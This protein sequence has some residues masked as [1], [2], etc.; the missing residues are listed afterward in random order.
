MSID[1]K[2]YR[3]STFPVK[4]VGWYNMTDGKT[5][6]AANYLTDDDENDYKYKRHSTLKLSETSKF[7]GLRHWAIKTIGGDDQEIETISVFKADTGELW[8]QFYSWDDDYDETGTNPDI[9]FWDDHKFTVFTFNPSETSLWFLIGIVDESDNWDMLGYLDLVSTGFDT[10]F[11]DPAN[12]E[13]FHDNYWPSIFFMNDDT[14]VFT[15]F[16]E[17]STYTSKQYSYVF[18]KDEFLQNMDYEQTG[19]SGGDDYER[20]VA[21]S[22]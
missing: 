6:W 4:A 10:Y 1:D 9:D 22:T 18:D 2:Y 19:S 12:Y 3:D 17:R 11:I 20:E 5:V 13:L 16:Y 15:S 7:L 14:L 21:N 8:R